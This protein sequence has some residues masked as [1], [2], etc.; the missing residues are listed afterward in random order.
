MEGVVLS[1]PS[2]RHLRADLDHAAGRD[3]EIFR[4][5]AGVDGELDEKLVLQAGEQVVGYLL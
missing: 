3:M 2:D 4:R 1:G 5:V